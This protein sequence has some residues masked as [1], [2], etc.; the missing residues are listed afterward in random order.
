MTESHSPRSP[1]LAIN[2]LIAW[3]DP[4]GK[5]TIE[6]LL[7]VCHAISPGHEDEIEPR[8]D[9]FIV[10]TVD[11]DGTRDTYAKLR[12]RPREELVAALDPHGPIARVVPE[13]SRAAIEMYPNPKTRGKHGS[14]R[15]KNYELIRPLVE[16]PRI[17]SSASYLS[18]AIY[19]RHLAA[20]RS[21][22]EIWM[23]LRRYWQG[24]QV[25][26]ALLAGYNVRLNDQPRE[27]P[28]GRKRGAKPYNYRH[29]VDDDE[30][31]SVG[32]E[33]RKNFEYGLNKFF[34][35]KKDERNTLRGAYEDT[36]DRFYFEVKGG[37]QVRLPPDQLPTYRQF[38]YFYEK[39]FAKRPTAFIIAKNG[40]KRYNQ[41]GRPIV[42][43]MTHEAFGPGDIY[44]MDATKA[45]IELVDA[46]GRII[47]R[48]WVYLVIDVFS[49]MPAGLCVT[50]EE[51][52]YIGAALALENAFAD[53]VEFC[54]SYGIPIEPGEW[55][56]H[57]ICNGL[58]ADKGELIWPSADRLTHYFNISLTN[59][60]AFRPDW[61]SIIERFFGRFNQKTI[62]RAPGA[63]YKPAER[64]DKDPRDNATLTLHEF[65]KAMI[66]TALM[67]MG[68]PL[69][70]YPLDKALRKA[71]V[72]AQ[73][74]ALWD[75]GMTHRTGALRM[76]AP[77][78]V[79]RTL[80]PR[81][82][83]KITQAGMSYNNLYYTRPGQ[84]FHEWM[85]A[86]GYGDDIPVTVAYDPRLVDGVFI[87]PANGGDL[88]SCSL[89]Q[90]Q[91]FHGLSW[92]EVE[93]HWTERRQGEKAVFMDVAPKNAE[94]KR[95]V[96]SLFE[97]ASTRQKNLVDRSAS[98]RSRLSG[99][100]SNRNDQKRAIRQDE[101]WVG[102]AEATGDSN[103][104]APNGDKVASNGDHPLPSEDG[105]SAS[106]LAIEKSS[107]STTEAARAK[108]LEALLDARQR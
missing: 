39:E 9:G 49:H 10:I 37:K 76:M 15:D 21:R 70:K 30:S 3:T 41:R 19:T 25:R 52:S 87:E 88:I 73:P 77:E 80:L 85:A 101:A 63:A 24:G 40:V 82:A 2:Q 32:P 84:L 81:A 34:I 54:A 6:R 11:E 51:P 5:V 78:L 13:T 67:F 58:K 29:D 79:K 68:E 59:L 23:Y 1:E 61:K 99:I 71:E 83:A 7:K 14:R 69:A 94:H 35:E 17:Y 33:D 105:P 66:H 74:L 27:A 106:F 8:D 28:E 16:D 98:K 64:G 26:D 102:G 104:G 38:F 42:G 103:N 60:P 100:K 90:D 55:P 47:G 18:N 44:E 56:C 93:R 46:A 12:F 108:R 57:H 43:N 86:A 95:A 50:L 75:W 20:K 65:T 45:D 4:N 89:R 36:L 31:F 62:H 91:H 92:A 97:I 96:D 107:V 48:P 22:T 72:P 53:K